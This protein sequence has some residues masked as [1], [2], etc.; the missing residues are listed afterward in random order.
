VEQTDGVSE[1][2]VTSNP[3]D[4]VAVNVKPRSATALGTDDTVIVWLTVATPKLTVADVAPYVALPVC[5]AV[6]VHVP[7]VSRETAE[8]LTEQTVGVE[9]E[10]TTGRPED[11]LAVS[12]SLVNAACEAGV[13]NVTVCGLRA[14]ENETLL[15][16][17]PLD[18][19]VMEALPCDTPATVLPLTVTALPLT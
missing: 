7:A 3:E 5:V 18:E 9:V 13:G 1:L 8:P 11:A 6:T 16:V 17:T 12:T 4:A 19:A 2:R 15:L 10:Y 14:I